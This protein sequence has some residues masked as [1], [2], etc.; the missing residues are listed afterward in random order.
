MM[1]GNGSEKA[2]LIQMLRLCVITAV[3]VT[4]TDRK[5]L[6]TRATS[7][8]VTDGKPPPQIAP[9]QGRS[10]RDTRYV[11]TV[12]LHTAIRDVRV[13]GCHAVLRKD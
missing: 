7:V 6:C 12:N 5:W 9:I 3:F 4:I 11:R 13:P 1:V 8:S 2:A 10:E